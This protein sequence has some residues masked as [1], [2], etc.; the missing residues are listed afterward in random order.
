MMKNVD[1][2]QRV[3]EA[4]ALTEHQE[5]TCAGLDEDRL[6][7]YADLTLAGRDPVSD[8]PDVYRHLSLCPD[9][10]R[11]YQDLR[12]TLRLEQ[13]NA[14]V[15]P[16]TIPNVDLS[17][18]PAGDAESAPWAEVA[19]RVRRYATQVP[20]LALRELER[21][22]HLPAGLYLRPAVGAPAKMR[23]PEVATPVVHFR[24]TDAEAHLAV[25]LRFRRAGTDVVWIGVEPLDAQTDGPLSGTVVALHD[26][27][28]RLLEMRTVPA[29]GKTQL[30]DVPID[31]E[32]LLRLEHAERA[33]E[34][35]FS[36]HV[37]DSDEDPMG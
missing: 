27:E 20:V 2:L 14:W 16:A 10:R 11:D 19:D 25:D 17:F 33:W 15:E 6:A 5:L 26:G 37:E 31:R 35:P 1:Q 32:F 36:L 29:E 28:G 12:A 18:L 23:G 9:C 8:M 7:T 21:L 34:I 3:L 30:R 22:G 4:V 13:T 24:L